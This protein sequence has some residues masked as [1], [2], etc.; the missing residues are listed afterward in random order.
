MRGDH[1]IITDSPSSNVLLS[2]LMNGSR[3]RS[4]GSDRRRAPRRGR[5]R[6]RSTRRVVPPHRPE[7]VVLPSSELHEPSSS[8]KQEEQISNINIVHLHQTFVTKHAAYTYWPT[9]GAYRNTTKND[10]GV[11]CRVSYL[12]IMSEIHEYLLIR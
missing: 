9:M 5:S 10:N 8:N 11:D 12:P 3:L 2:S 4:L 7:D 1:S 6:I